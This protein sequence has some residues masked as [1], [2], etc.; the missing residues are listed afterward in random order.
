MNEIVNTPSTPPPSGNVRI[1]GQIYQ[2]ARV[3]AALQNKSVQEVINNALNSSLPK[4]PE[5]IAKI[6]NNSN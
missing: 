1:D 2:R 3:F 5:T 6:H 4:L